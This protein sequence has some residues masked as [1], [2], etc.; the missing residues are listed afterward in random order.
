VTLF[1]KTFCKIKKPS[2]YLAIMPKRKAF[3]DRIT[4]INSNFLLSLR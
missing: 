2:M 4:I 1:I 3:G